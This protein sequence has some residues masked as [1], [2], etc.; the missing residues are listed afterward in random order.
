MV[1]HTYNPSSLRPAWATEKDL[2]SKKTK[3]Q[4]KTQNETTNT[5]IHMYVCVYGVC[6]CV[7]VCVCTCICIW[8][9]S[10]LPNYFRNVMQSQSIFLQGMCKHF[11]DYYTI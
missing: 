6:V 2:V 4:T 5:Y 10:F 3:T 1:V 9:L 7:C 8:R 11:L